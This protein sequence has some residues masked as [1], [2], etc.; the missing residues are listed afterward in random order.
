MN[1]T[2][3]NCCHAAIADVGKDITSLRVVIIRVEVRIFVM[4]DAKVVPTNPQTKCQAVCCFPR[5]LQ[6]GS[7]F[8]VTIAPSK[9]WWANWE[10][11]CTAR[12]DSGCAAREFSLWIDGRLELCELPGQEI[13]DAGAEVCSA[14]G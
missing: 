2:V 3:R 5:I 13:F 4:L 14:E 8:M 10:R 9:D 7:E 6:V 1:G 12:N 11:Y